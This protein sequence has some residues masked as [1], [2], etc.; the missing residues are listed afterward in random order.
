M[1]A[2]DPT[3]GYTSTGSIVYPVVKFGY[4]AGASADTG[5]TASTNTLRTCKFTLSAP[6]TLKKITV[7]F[8]NVSGSYHCYTTASI[9]SDSAGYPATKQV[10]SAMQDVQAGG[11]RDFPVAATFLLASTWH[12]ETNIYVTSVTIGKMVYDAGVA[13]QT[14]RITGSYGGAN[15]V[16]PATF[17]GGA[18]AYSY[19]MYIAGYGCA[20]MGYAKAY[21]FSLSEVG[22]ATSFS[23]YPHNAGNGRF[24]IFSVS[25]GAPNALL[26]ESGSE[27]LVATT[28]KSSTIPNV[29][30]IVGD[31]ALAWQ[32]DTV[33]DVPSYTAGAAGMGNYI[34]QAYGAFPATWAGGTATAEKWSMYVTYIAAEFISVTD[35]GAGTDTIISITDLLTIYETGVGTD[36]V[37]MQGELQIDGVQ[38]PHVQRIHIAEPSNLSSKPL[39]EGLPSRRWVG[40]QG[41]AAD[42]EGWTDSLTTL[43]EVKALADGAA[44]WIQLPDGTAFSA[45]ITGVDP[46]HPTSP[47]MYPY[48]LHAEERM[49]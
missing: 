15:P 25:G 41:R 4:E 18:T 20:I 37:Y 6:M 2:D 29:S 42:F 43:E 46:R 36:I 35:S 26:W 7:A 45:H 1:P 32:V 11:A 19:K 40:K 3:F 34:V 10:E 38:P 48:T 8:S 47:D 13:N 23:F 24:A 49:D 21:I 9:Y 16:S 22:T 28:W 39:L 17:P 31:Y 12:L 14:Y 30:L 27:A 33:N 44:H 5:G